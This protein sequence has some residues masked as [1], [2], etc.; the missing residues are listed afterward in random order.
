M[1]FRILFV[2]IIILFPSQNA[3][4]DEKR[5]IPINFQVLEFNSVASNYLPRPTFGDFVVKNDEIKS[6]YLR[7][8]FVTPSENTAFTRGMELHWIKKKHLQSYMQGV[9][10][11]L[12]WEEVALRDGDVFT[13][14]IGK[15]G[16]SIFTFH[17]GNVENHY[18]EI[19]K[20]SA[21]GD[22][23]YYYDRPAAEGLLKLLVSWN[24]NEI[25]TLSSSELEDKYK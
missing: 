13:K 25:D 20:C 14:E 4:A 18:L 10:K 17:S 16:K 24:N 19:S 3:L 11:F 12:S 8:D 22:S 1:F 7:A 6:L 5:R 21:C 2:V 23:A 9:E 15:F